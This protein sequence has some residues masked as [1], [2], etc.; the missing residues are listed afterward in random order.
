MSKLGTEKIISGYSTKPVLGLS[1]SQSTSVK[2]TSVKST[3]VQSLEAPMPQFDEYTRISPVGTVIDLSKVNIPENDNRQINTVNDFLTQYQ[4]RESKEAIPFDRFANE[5]SD[6]GYYGL[7][8]RLFEFSDTTRVEFK[9]EFKGLSIQAQVC[10]N[11]SFKHGQ[12]LSVYNHWALQNLLSD[13]P[14]LYTAFVTQKV[15]IQVTRPIRCFCHN[16]PEGMNDYYK[17]RRITPEGKKAIEERKVD[18]LKTMFDY[19]ERLGGKISFR[20]LPHFVQYEDGLAFCD[21]VKMK[22][23]G[24]CDYS[25]KEVC[26]VYNESEYPAHHKIRNFLLYVI[27]KSLHT[28]GCI[29]ARYSEILKGMDGLSSLQNTYH[30]IDDYI[31]YTLGVPDLSLWSQYRDIVYNQ[32]L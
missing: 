9:G 29:D 5:E 30:S 24:G 19:L 21:C 32:S 18:E 4:V 31:T 3:S 1:P 15:L 11:W 14:K 10:C 28:C 27:H 23:K 26:L 12:I 22:V 17:F 8:Q 7:F 13:Y 6:T 2:S 25:E 20:S 16:K